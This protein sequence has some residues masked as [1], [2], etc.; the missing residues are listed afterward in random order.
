MPERVPWRNEDISMFLSEGNHSIA[1]LCH[2]LIDR[3][4]SQSYDVV[5]RKWYIV[6]NNSASVWVRLR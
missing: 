6:E 3:S 2:S 4:D 1:L 5:E